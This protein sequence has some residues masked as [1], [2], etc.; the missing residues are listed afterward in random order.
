MSAAR[1]IVNGLS[2]LAISGVVVL[3]VG[4]GGLA[5]AVRCNQALGDLL[6]GKR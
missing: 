5:L 3:A 6:F 1:T 2:I 4:I